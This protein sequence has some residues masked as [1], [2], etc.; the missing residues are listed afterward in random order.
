MTNCGLH[1]S[2]EALLMLPPFDPNTNQMP[3]S[4]RWPLALVLFSRALA[5][6]LVDSIKPSKGSPT[7][8]LGYGPGGGGGEAKWP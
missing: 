7:L 5:R 2:L 4:G 3:K 1:N 8:P 6:R